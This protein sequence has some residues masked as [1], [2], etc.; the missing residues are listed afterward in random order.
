MH[1]YAIA[2]RGSEGGW[3]L[4]FP[5]GGAG[6]YSFAERPEDINP[7]AQDWLASS[8]MH[9]GTLP[10]SIEDG[11]MPP[12]LADLAGFEDPLIVVIPYV[13]AA[14]AKEAA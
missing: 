9:G 4:T 10:R 6:G 1:Y 3:F 8:A 2:E 14:K 13:P 5:H 12:T 7:Q 11:A